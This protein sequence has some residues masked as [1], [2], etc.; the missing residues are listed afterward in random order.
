MRG[1]ARL[2]IAE[3]DMT[4][5]ADVGAE[6]PCVVCGEPT[7]YVGT[8]GRGVGGTWDDS[9]TDRDRVLTP[10]DDAGKAI[11]PW[12]ATAAK[13]WRAQWSKRKAD[14]LSPAF[15]T[16]SGL[17]YLIADGRVSV[18]SAGISG[19]YELAGL[20]ARD[21]PFAVLGGRWQ[22][23]AAHWIWAPVAYPHSRWPAMWVNGT[24][25]VIWVDGRALQAIADEASSAG[26]YDGEKGLVAPKGSRGGVFRFVNS[27]TAMK[28]VRDG[29]GQYDLIVGTLC[30][31]PPSHPS[32]G[33]P[34]TGA[35]GG[36]DEQPS[37][38]TGNEGA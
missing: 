11:C 4:T 19:L 16:A 27:L 36:G 10:L 28:G 31:T 21:E 33:N 1:V 8:T 35:E 2:G 26:A 38:G 15:A 23:M 7:S 18:V 6:R 37:S 13:L 34:G 22:H 24:A 25:R 17:P 5:V 3:P 29:G 30:A 32:T 14:Y 9:F 20:T 12:C